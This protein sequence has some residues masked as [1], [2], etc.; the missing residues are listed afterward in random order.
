M[1]SVE[2]LKFS[3]GE[4]Y[5]MLVDDTGMPHFWLT[6]YITSQ[7]RPVG[8][9]STISSYITDIRH[10]MLWEEVKNRNIFAEFHNLNFLKEEDAI[11]LRD[12]CLLKTKDV[13]RWHTFE[14]T[15][16]IRKINKDFPTTPRVLDR[17]SGDHAKTRMT[18]I[19][20]Y[21][22][23]T[24]R[25]MLRNR[26]NVEEINENIKVM[27]ET[28]LAHLPKGGNSSSSSSNPDDKAPDLEVF[29]QLMEAV[30]SDSSNNPY[31]N[32]IAKVRNA[33]MFN[34]LYDT[35][36]RSAE[37]LGLKLEDIDYHGNIITIK[38]R[39]DDQ[40]DPRTAQPVVKTLS[41]DIPVAEELIKQIMDYIENERANT[42]GANN[43][44]YLFVTHQK[45]EYVGSPLSNSGFT[46]MVKTA[47]RKIGKTAED[48]E[49]EDLIN[50]IKRHGF[51][52]NFNNKLSKAFD[53][54]NELA[55]TDKSVKPLSEREQNQIRMQ[56]NGW[57][58]EDTANTYN[59]RHIKE[60]ARKIMYED[61]QSQSK[62]LKK[63]R[64]KE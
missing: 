18:R 30:Q 14:S 33:V 52:H 16:K 40:D 25:A 46:A 48:F 24:A 42:E 2:P 32:S 6:L 41:R 3:N 60:E 51:R 62:W 39:H 55:K 49:K 23:F 53:K 27:Q 58:S 5:S 59:Q 9:Q 36:A 35:G 1:H 21:L 19:A 34:T 37:L 56:L 17:V 4:R 8:T 38:R 45:G 22:A 47:V 28:L 12:H 11:S 44:P 13:R 43:H 15:K 64:E 50:E 20:D 54:R 31:K 7:V 10:F 57:S 63:L 26:P 29:D 61:M